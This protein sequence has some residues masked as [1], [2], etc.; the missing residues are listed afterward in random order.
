MSRVSV[1]SRSATITQRLVAATPANPRP[2]NGVDQ[3][4]LGGSGNRAGRR[5]TTPSRLGPRQPG[6][7]SVSTVVPSFSKASSRSAAPA[8]AA[9]WAGSSK[10]TNPNA[11]SKAISRSGRCLTA[12]RASR[13]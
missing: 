1:A 6:Q 5:A 7:A 8:R 10:G 13:I 12:T 2:V 4:T 9:E 3:S 11:V